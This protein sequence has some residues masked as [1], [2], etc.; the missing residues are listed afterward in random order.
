MMARGTVHHVSLLGTRLTSAPAWPPS[1]GLKENNKELIKL[2]LSSVLM[3]HSSLAAV[4][5]HLKCLVVC[6][7][8]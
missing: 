4:P 5:E 6:F 8:L 7:A 1:A 2:K 3:L